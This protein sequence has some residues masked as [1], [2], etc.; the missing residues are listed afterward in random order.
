MHG[1]KYSTTTCRARRARRKQLIISQNSQEKAGNA[2]ILPSTATER[3]GHLSNSRDVTGSHEIEV[4]GS[5]IGSQ[6]S[7]IG[8]TTEESR[9]LATTG[10]DKGAVLEGVQC[11]PYEGALLEGVQPLTRQP[12]DVSGDAFA[13]LSLLR[14]VDTLDIT[15]KRIT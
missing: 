3:D 6:G 7:E 10:I 14:C 11:L 12:F 2:A 9:A 13:S 8:P 5:L 15:V 4:G 1:L